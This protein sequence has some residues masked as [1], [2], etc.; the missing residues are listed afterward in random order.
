[1]EGRTAWRGI[2]VALC[3]CIQRHVASRTDLGR[4]NHKSRKNKVMAMKK[5]YGRLWAR[6]TAPECSYT[7]HKMSW[8]SPAN[9]G[10]LPA[11]P[12]AGGRPLWLKDCLGGAGPSQ[13]RGDG[14]GEGPESRFFSDPSISEAPAPISTVLD[15]L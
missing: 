2:T 11:H 14:R 7:S 3:L 8:T 1:M 4:Q 13:G 6:W 12:A 15:V 10:G 5:S 9:P